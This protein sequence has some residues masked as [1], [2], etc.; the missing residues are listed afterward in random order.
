M[1]SSGSGGS[2][3]VVEHPLLS[4]YSNSRNIPQFPLVFRLSY[5]VLG[6]ITLRFC[7]PQFFLHKGGTIMHNLHTTAFAS[8]F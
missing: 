8:T 6:I 2:S 4:G 1:S 5:P 3:R 7:L